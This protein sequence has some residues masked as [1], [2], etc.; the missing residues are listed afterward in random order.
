MTDPESKSNVG[1]PPNDG[2]TAL[3]W[4]QIR[5]TSR[6]KAAYVHAAKGRK[7]SEW[8]FEHLDKAAGYNAAKEDP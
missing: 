6:R 1:R 8:V 5:V 4:I 3:S 2:E 7:L